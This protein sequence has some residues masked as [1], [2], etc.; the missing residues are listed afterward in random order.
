MKSL[1][2]VGL[3][4]LSC[5]GCKETVGKFI[6]DNSNISNIEDYIYE[7]D[8]GKIVSQTEV[9][10]VLMFNE[11]VDKNIFR[12]IYEYNDKQLLERELVYFND[13]MNPDRYIY[14]YNSV[15]SLI[16]KLNIS[17]EGDTTELVQFDYFP[18]GRQIVFSRNIHISVLDLDPGMESDLFEMK[19][20]MDMRTYD[21]IIFRNEYLYENNLCKIWKQYDINNH[22]TKVVEYEY[23]NKKL[24]KISHYLYADSLKTLDMIG[25]YD[26]SKSVDF[27]DYF[28]TGTNKND[29]ISKCIN[30]FDKGELILTTEIS[31][32]GNNI[33]KTY[34][35]KGKV[36]GVVLIDKELKYSSKELYAYYSNGNLK[37]IKRKTEL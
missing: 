12:R 22:L 37:Q 9:H 26:Y 19:K 27:P 13:E 23:D 24:A 29:T 32:R 2:F 7:Y 5:S 34:Y 15:D 25:Y 20:R 36:I 33:E 10:S 35:L 4:I 6:F 28:F 3:I 31:E 16:M 21:T 14:I 8:K 11:I 17:S 1:V 30:E 18:D